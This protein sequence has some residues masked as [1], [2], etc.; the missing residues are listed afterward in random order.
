MKTASLV[1]VGEFLTGDSNDSLRGD[2][3]KGRLPPD[4]SL[5]PAAI[6][7]LMNYVGSKSHAWLCTENTLLFP[8]RVPRHQGRQRAGQS[9]LKT[10]TP[11]RLVLLSA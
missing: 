4:V 10:W 3:N 8:Y 1:P 7:L 2:V 9:H 5:S 6:V 11:A